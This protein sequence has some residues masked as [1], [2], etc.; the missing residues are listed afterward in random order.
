MTSA[1]IDHSLET[2]LDLDGHVFFQPTGEWTK[3]E[4]RRVEASEGCPHGV[5]YSLTLHRRSGERLLGY[6][7]A[8]AVD[9][10]RKIEWD[11]K[12]IEEKILPYKYVDAG[13][14]LADFFAD[15]NRWLEDEHKDD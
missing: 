7:N 13:T 14:L 11:H 15:V 9:T 1:D 5:K 2:L 4:A 6:D 3:I 12:H 8:H 10:H